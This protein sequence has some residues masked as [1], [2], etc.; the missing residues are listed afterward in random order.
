[1]K[2]GMCVRDFIVLNE[3]DLWL[4]FALIEFKLCS[5]L[6]G[7]KNIELCAFEEIWRY[8]NEFNIQ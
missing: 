3:F 1:M 2:L 4:N 7:F 6:V 5:L 8:E